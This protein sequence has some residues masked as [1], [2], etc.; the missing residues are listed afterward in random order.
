[1]TTRAEQRAKL[2]KQIKKEKKISPIKPTRQQEIKFQKQLLNA[3]NVSKASILELYST[4]SDLTTMQAQID[5]AFSNLKVWDDLQLQAQANFNELNNIHQQKFY[6]SVDQG[7]G[8][9]VGAF[10]KEN[11]LAEL[12]KA[13]VKTNVDQITDL[14][15][16]VKKRVS[17]LVNHSLT[18]QESKS[19][20]LEKQLRKTFNKMSANEAKFIARDQTQRAVNGLNRFRQEAAGINKYKWQT[21][22]DNRVRT[23]KGDNHVIMNGL[24]VNWSTGKILPTKLAKQRGVANKNVKNIAG[25]HVGNSYNCRCTAIAI[26]ELIK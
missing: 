25:G 21:S 14:K 9:N 12:Q 4:S 17:N 10:I 16:N 6:N 20:S 5:L 8:V 15:E 26:L 24:E 11:G 18:G 1:M 3:V 2:F 22:Q 7:V 13:M 19:P 23:V